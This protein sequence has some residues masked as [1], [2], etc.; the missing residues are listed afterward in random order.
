MTST[1]N[2]LKVSFIDKDTR[3]TEETAITSSIPTKNAQMET[4][5]EK[6]TEDTTID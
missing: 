1:C 4:L 2:N 6:K 3:E 5:N